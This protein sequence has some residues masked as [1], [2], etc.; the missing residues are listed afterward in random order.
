[1][2]RTLR[3]GDVGPAVEAGKRSVFKY[4]GANKAWHEL[5]NKPLIVRRTFGPFFA[6]HVKSAQKKAGLP[7]TGVLGSL[8]WAALEKAGAIDAYSHYLIRKDDARYPALVY[9]IPIGHNCSVC[10]GLHPTY[11]LDG[12]WAMDW[13]AVGGTPVVAVEKAKIKKLSGRPPTSGADQLIGIFGWSIHYESLSGYRYFST[14]YGEREPLTIGQLVEPGQKIGE[15]GS[16]PGNPGRSHVH[17]GVTSPYG[18]KD[19]KKRMTSIA[20]AERVRMR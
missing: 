11:G 15:I 9:P 18:E 16:W 17:L 5:I 4:L 14:H 13:C 10:Q 1:V 8:T 2:P 7:Q 19:A 6:I 12:N 3:I 20:N